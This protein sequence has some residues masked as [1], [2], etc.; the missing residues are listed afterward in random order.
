MNQCD[1]WTL[2]LAV[3]ARD[4][5][6]ALRVDDTESIRPELM[7]L[8][9]EDRHVVLSL[10]FHRLMKDITTPYLDAIWIKRIRNQQIA[11][12]VC[13]SEIVAYQRELLRIDKLPGY[14]KYAAKCVLEGK[15]P[16][17]FHTWTYKTGTLPRLLSG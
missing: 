6:L 4:I 3:I 17:D 13:R 7:Q 2:K 1:K 15:D 12:S 9:R 16:W 5:H 11:L 10:V 14:P 8:D